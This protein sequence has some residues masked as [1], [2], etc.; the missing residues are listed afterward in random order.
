MFNF[1]KSPILIHDDKY[2][3]SNA[4]CSIWLFLLLPLEKNKN[5]KKIQNYRKLWLL[6]KRFVIWGK[7]S[8]WIFSVDILSKWKKYFILIIPQFS[9][10]LLRIFHH[11]CNN[12]L[13]ETSRNVI[14]K[15]SKSYTLQLLRKRKK[16]DAYY[17]TTAWRE[18]HLWPQFKQ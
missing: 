1:I 6:S 5:C 10:S 12:A 15:C 14:N 11:R 2:S 18:P 17:F 4:V 16:S 7:V 8:G 3:S 9:N 13:Q